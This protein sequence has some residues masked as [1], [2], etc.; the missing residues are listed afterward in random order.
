MMNRLFPAIVFFMT[1]SALSLLA[2]CTKND[3]VNLNN[4]IQIAHRGASGHAPENTLAAVKKALDM[5]VP[6]I[7]V[8]VHQTRDNHLVVMHDYTINRTTDGKGKVKDLTL[9]EIR[10]YDAGS[11]YSGNFEGEKVPLLQEVI[12]LVDG[13]ATL[14]IEIK[15]KKTLYPGISGR[16]AETIRGNSIHGWCIVQ[17]FDLEVLSDIHKIDSSIRLH[18]LMI[19]RFLGNVFFDRRFVVFRL[20]EYDFISSVNLHKLFAGRRIIRKIHNSGKKVMVWTVDSDKRKRKMVKKGVD[21]IIT[22]FP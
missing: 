14:L 7:E 16:V 13:R 20:N 4:V 11:W 3:T 1:F 10:N 6:V 21:G 15:K 5:N 17:S 22:N 19:G 18:K 9:S 12:D 2:G 8:D